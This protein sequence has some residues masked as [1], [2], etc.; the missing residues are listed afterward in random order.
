MTAQLQ[1]LPIGIQH[2]ETLRKNDYLYVD[3]TARLL[4]LIRTGAWYFLARPRRFGKSLTVST[5]D[6]M[7]SGKA[8]LFA[9]LAAEDWVHEK[10]RHPAPVLRLDMSTMTS[11]TPE[12][13][14]QSLNAALARRARRAGLQL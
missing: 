6:A 3:K 14:R 1:N 7:F 5:L 11:D 9:G 8:D 4:Q 12:T 10:A 13:L 2:F